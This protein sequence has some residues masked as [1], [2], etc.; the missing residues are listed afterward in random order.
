MGEA[1]FVSHMK[2]K[3]HQAAASAANSLAIADS[4]TTERP[5]SSN[6]SVS[7]ATMQTTTCTDT[8]N[9]VLRA[10]ILWALKIMNSHYSFK[11]CEDTS[12]LFATMFRDS[13]MCVWD[14]SSFQKTFTVRG[15]KTNKIC[16]AL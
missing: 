14:C 8:K 7:S 5:S 12:H 16:H 1:A 9:K 15:V 13:E 2:G 3:K 6:M 11:S 4:M 10:E